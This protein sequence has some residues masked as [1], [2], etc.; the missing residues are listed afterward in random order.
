MLAQI[1]F[2]LI[3]L[4]VLLMTIFSFSPPT[5]PLANNNNTENIYWEQDKDWFTPTRW[6]TDEEIDWAN[7]QLIINDHHLI[8]PA[9][10]FHLVR[11]KL[12]EPDLLA[13]LLSH[14]TN[15]ENELVFI[16]VNNPNF[17]WSLLVYETWSGTFYHYDT[18]NGANYEYIKPLVS[19]LLQQINHPNNP[20]LTSDL[21]PCHNIHQ[22]N[23]YDC[24]IAVISII[25]R[26][27]VKYGDDMESIRLG[28]FDFKQERQELRE[29]YLVEN[30][31]E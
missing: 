18:L 21:I 5:K 25:K 26:I 2:L 28:K 4:I 10:Q 29:K 11:E 15:K 17:H 16:P 20:D 1:I 13:G 8:L 19:E 27:S 9:T 24:G 22:N 14:L 30:N 12:T 23:G 7:K 6:L 3:I 31:D